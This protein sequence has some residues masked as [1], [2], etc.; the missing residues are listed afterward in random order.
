VKMV[1]EFELEL[2]GRKRTAVQ[3]IPELNSYVSRCACV[4]NV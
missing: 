1:G 4:V 2:V 3:W